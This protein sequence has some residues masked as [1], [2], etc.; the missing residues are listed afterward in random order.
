MVAGVDANS[1]TPTSGGVGGL[2][3]SDRSLSTFPDRL[4]YESAMS[5]THSRIRNMSYAREM[6]PSVAPSGA[7]D[8][9]N[10][11]CDVCV[12]LACRVRTCTCRGQTF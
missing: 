10:Q 6:A 2:H 5:S 4:F 3:F 8:P 12:L 1:D 11:S 7:L 9:T